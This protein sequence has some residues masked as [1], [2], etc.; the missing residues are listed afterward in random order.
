MFDL[1]DAVAVR[2]VL[3]VL[4]AKLDGKAAAASVYQRKRAVLFN[5]LS[6]AVERELIPDNPLNRVKRKAAKVVDQVDPRVVANPHQ[7]AELLTA[8][9][10]V[11]SRNKDRGAHLAAFFATG[12]YSAARP[13]EGLGL[14]EDDCTL[15]AEGWGSLA[16][17]ESRP[18]AGKRWT[19]SGEV[20]D[21]RGLKHR[22]AKEVRIVPIPPVLVAML[23]DH[24]DRYGSGPDGRLF[25]S[26]SGGVVSSSTYYRVW[27]D[28]RQY[29]LTPAQVA[30][31]LAGRPYDLRHA[32]VSLW[33]NGGVPA[34][35]VAERAG[36]SVDVLLKV[37]AKCID[38][39]RETVNKKIE[40][41]FEA[42]A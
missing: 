35:E 3:D 17:G 11:G 27:D 25:R 13:A 18:A 38:G 28:A 40:E 34:T 37:Y 8:V 10:Y 24:L 32:A 33:L 15:P 19:D 12:Y 6:Y 41:L 21:R 16:L 22:G 31:P 36:H 5:L 1:T 20:H 23:R 39:Q 42:A 4:A 9:S 29:A 26:Q 30:S 14:R 7:V 2:E